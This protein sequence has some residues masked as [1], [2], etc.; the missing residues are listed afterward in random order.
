MNAGIDVA[1]RR[2]CRVI[3]STVV[4]AGPGLAGAANVLERP[5]SEGGLPSF[6]G[7][8]AWLNSPPLAPD[9]LRGKVVL[10]QFWTYSCI[11]WLRTLPYVRAWAG[12][13]RDDGLAVIGV[14]TPEFGFEQDLGN[15]RRAVKAMGIAYPVAV[16]NGRAVWQAFDNA[17]WPALY[18]VDAD[19]RVRAHKFGEGDYEQSEGLIQALLA[20]SGRAHTTRTLASVK[21][22]GREAAADWANLKSPENYLGYARTEHFASPGGPAP[23]TPRVY[24]A[25]ERLRLNQW[26]LSGG[27]TLHGQPAVANTANGRIACRFHARD[28][29]MV[30]GP[31]AGSAPVPFRIRLDGEAPGASHGPDVDA[32]GLGSIDVPRLY[33]LVRQTPPIVDRVFTIEFLQPRVEA[34]AFTFG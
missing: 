33:Q 13:Y 27:W 9:A 24:V 26:A 1:R 28:L 4:S 16:D 5:P 31:G 15:L 29:H 30:L 34:F 19:G 6:D 22:D 12:H 21:V 32:Q 8:T 2:A 25:P 10:V 20:E 3:A 17:Y 14:H 11:N 23:D 18:F 7:A